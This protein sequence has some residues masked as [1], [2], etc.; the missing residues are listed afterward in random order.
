MGQITIIVFSILGSVASVIALLKYEK[1]WQILLIH[2][3]YCISIITLS[4]LWISYQNKFEELNRIENQARSVITSSQTLSSSG[5]QRG[6][7]LAS[8]AFLE[9]YKERFPETYKMALMLCAD[10]GVTNS[11]P[12]DYNNRVAQDYRLEDAS[13]AMKYLL[14]GIAAGK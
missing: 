13:V 12:V 14:S 8:L 9:K 3:G 6:F 1:K 10:V 7:I 2:I 11:R 5:A 4:A